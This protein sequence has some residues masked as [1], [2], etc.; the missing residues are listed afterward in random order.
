MKTLAQG[1]FG[2]PEAVALDA[3][4][5]ALSLGAQGIVAKYYPQV[6]MLDFFTLFAVSHARKG[7][8]ALTC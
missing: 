7:T 8:T 2:T 1:V 3:I 6:R 5:Q 4:A